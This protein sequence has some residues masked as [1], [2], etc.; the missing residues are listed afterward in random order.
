M[1]NIDLN[2]DNYTFEDI[3]KLFKINKNFTDKDLK[4]CK[5]VLNWIPQKSIINY[6]RKIND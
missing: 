2:I 3:L 6:L 4:K 5:E 1:N